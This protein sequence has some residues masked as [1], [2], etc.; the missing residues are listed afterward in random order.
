M[1]STVYQRVAE[2]ANFLI[3]SKAALDKQD[4]AAK[5]GYNASSFSQIINGRVPVS[6][7]F[8]EKLLLFAP[9]LN[10]K[11]LL[12]GDGNMLNTPPAVMIPYPEDE[13]SGIPDQHDA[14]ARAMN[15]G[16][17]PV[18]DASNIDLSVVPIE[19]IKEIR[20]EIRE[21][22]AVAVIPA[23]VANQ[24]GVDIKKYIEENEGELK[25]LS[26]NDITGDADSAVEIT[27]NS[28][29]PAYVPGDKIFLKFLKHK[30]HIT[31][32][33]F[34]YFNIKDK[35]SIIRQAKIEGD[36]IRLLALNPQFGDIVTNF[37]NV[38]RVADIKGMYREFVSN[39]YSEVE[40]V[41]RKKEEQIDKLIDQNAK[42]LE[43]IGNLVD[44]IKNR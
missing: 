12:T 35:P 7:K 19:L 29:W 33:T 32:G 3:F 43:S 4:L 44:V 1:K 2:V 30:T 22:N 6:H 38:L 14:M 5:L 23:E 37:D 16:L 15:D 28:M 24:V 34:Y 20:E 27:M 11:W 17:S 40:T 31:D 36:R 10:E 39:Q 25:K 26:P 41:R 42:A 8:L 18:S 13:A 21:E 9:N